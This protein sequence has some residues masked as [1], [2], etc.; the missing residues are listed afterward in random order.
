M[1]TTT[2]AKKKVTTVSPDDVQSLDGLHAM[3]DQEAEKAIQGGQTYIA[4]ILTEL[5]AHVDKE[6]TRV[7]KFS[8]R[9]SVADKRNRVRTLRKNQTDGQ[10]G[11]DTSPTKAPPK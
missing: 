8:K 6:V 11:T 3:L 1:A 7:S 2:T 4:G 10:G 9:L 5:L